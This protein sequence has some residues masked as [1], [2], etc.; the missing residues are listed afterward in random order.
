[1]SQSADDMLNQ[2]DLD[3]R[4]DLLNKLKIANSRDVIIEIRNRK[5]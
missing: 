2:E 5:H 1:M 3:T 4:Y